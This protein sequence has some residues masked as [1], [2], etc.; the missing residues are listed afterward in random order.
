MEDADFGVC[1]GSRSTGLAP[2][3]GLERGLAFQHCAGDGEQ[4]VRDAAERAGM[5]VAA[6][7][8]GCVFGPA[9]GVMLYG[10]ASPV[11]EGNPH[12]S[13]RNIAARSIPKAR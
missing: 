9:D 7:S 1:G 10:D 6:G 11:V 5:T 13:A 2:E 4:S 3:V 12:S 8:Q